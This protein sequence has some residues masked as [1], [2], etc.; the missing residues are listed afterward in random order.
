ML[1]GYDI[2]VVQA[3]LGD[4][5]TID[6]IEGELALDIPAGVQPGQQV[7]LKGQGLPP[8]HGGKRG[9]LVVELSVQ[10]PTKVSEGEAKLL[11]DFAELRGERI[12]KEKGGF[13][14]GIFGK[15]K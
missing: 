9:D 14:D 12:P 4:E 3:V 11:R 13:L 8:V 7:I 5:V 1:T 15:K 6:G 10:I 2:S